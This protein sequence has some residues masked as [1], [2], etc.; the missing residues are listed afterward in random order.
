MWLQ[1]CP[2]GVIHEDLMKEICAKFFPHGSEYHQ[3][4]KKFK[5]KF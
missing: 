4:N 1:D 5:Y 3:K 2:E